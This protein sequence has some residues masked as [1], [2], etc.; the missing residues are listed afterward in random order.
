MSRRRPLRLATL[1]GPN[2]VDDLGRIAAHLGGRGPEPIIVDLQTAAPGVADSVNNSGIDVLWACGLL[3]AELVT[4]G[5]DLDVVAAPV[6][7]GETAAVYRSVIVT[8]SGGD[9]EGRRLA[10]NELGSWSGYRALFHDAVVRGDN[11]RHPDRMDEIVVTGAHIASIAAVAQGRAD[12]AAIDHSIWNWL[13]ATDPEVVDGLVVVDETV[14]CPAPP[15]SLGPGIR[16]EDRL[17][18]T[19][20]LL[21]FDGPP[22]LA[23]ASIDDYRFMLA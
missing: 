9:A 19:E 7:A 22:S 20:A 2:T 23:P 3:T 14:D 13:C 17:C 10:V 8:R 12:V 18:V 11:R 6:F 21:G 5:L 16:G 15:L 4:G 1:L